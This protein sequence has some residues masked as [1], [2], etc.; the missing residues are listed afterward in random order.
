MGNRSSVVNRDVHDQIAALQAAVAA[1]QEG[2]RARHADTEQKFRRLRELKR[3]T[4]L[5]CAALRGDVATARRVVET[6]K[7][8]DVEMMM[9]TYGAGDTPVMF[10][11][12]GMTPLALAAM[13]GHIDIVLTFL[14]AG[15]D[16]NDVCQ[17]SHTPLGLAAS[18]CRDQVIAVLLAAGANANAKAA[19]GSTPLFYA[20]SFGYEAIVRALIDA[21][22]D[23]NVK[24]DDGRTAL[25]LAKTDAVRALLR[26]A[27]AT[28]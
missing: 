3:D 6:F 12:D 9:R 7:P 22:A 10:S 23:I 17:N 21:G 19:D 27:G 8:S 1:L 14:R 26:G 2:A 16:V 28:A 5:H 4:E 11:W 18:N 25:S 24:S 13:H 20:A 15:A